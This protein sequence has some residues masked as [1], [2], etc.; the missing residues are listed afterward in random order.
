MRRATLTAI[1]AAATL[2]PLPAGA[3]AEPTA[4][5]LPL[6][7]EGKLPP[8]GKAKF[9]KA[10]DEGLARTGVTFVAPA[11]LAGASGGA[12]DACRDEACL[13]GVAAKT[14]TTHLVRPSVRLE[15]S[16]YVIAIA[17]ID[18]ASGRVVHEVSEV[19]ELCGLS[20]AL[21]LASTLAASLAPQLT[22]PPTGTVTVE[23][24]P[25]GAQVLVDGEPAGTTPLELTLAPGEH[26]IVIRHEGHVDD[27]R[28]VTVE[29]GAASA[30]AA[31]LR[32]VVVAPIVEDERG[33]RDGLLRPLGW[34]SLG[35]GI[36][37]LGAGIA[38]L[39]IDGKP[40][41]FT[42]CSGAD[43]DVEGNCRFRHDTLA[44]G[45]VMT[46]VGVVGITAGAV[47][48][49]RAYGKRGKADQRRAR[50]RPTLGGMAIQF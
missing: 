33:R 45:V 40:V 49:A 28:S 29:V 12:L 39:A 7:V 5:V 11:E 38:L 32:P 10:L 30:V 2:L 13:Q 16:D 23:S 31:E 41:E 43:V 46:V 22:A 19:C 6:D 9:T 1:V 3:T 18:G 36:A 48:V 17:I 50:L 42:R 26:R 44:G 35:V 24:T 14:S 21:T 4:G 8:K 34:A 25:A 27:E 20:E 15:E 37:S 47:L